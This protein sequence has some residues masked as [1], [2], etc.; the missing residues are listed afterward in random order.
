MHLA[1]FQTGSRVLNS[2]WQLW[3]EFIGTL[4]RVRV[5]CKMPGQEHPR[6]IETA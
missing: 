1:D 4:Q 3:F 2:A 6:G 5:I